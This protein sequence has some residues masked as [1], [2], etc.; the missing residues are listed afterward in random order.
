MGILRFNYRSEVLGRYV[1][2]TV[3]L[4][5]DSYRC[6]PSEKLENRTNRHPVD[7]NKPCYVPGMKFQTVY[8]IHGGGDDDTLTYR[9]SNVEEVAQRNHVMLVTPNIA[10]SFGYDAAYT[11]PYMTFVTEELPTVIQSLF[12]SSTARE[13]NFIMGYAMGGNVALGCAV[14]RPDRYA[15]C[16]D[17]SGG[18][19][20]TMST[21]T[22]M[23]ELD[24]DHFKQFFPL[25]NTTFGSSEEI[26]GSAADLAY[27]VKQHRENGDPEC[28]FLLVCGSREFIR[29][30]VERDAAVMQ[31][32]HMDVTYI[33]AEEYDHDFKLWDRY[34]QLGLDTLLPLKRKA[35][36]PVNAQ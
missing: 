23:E 5:T 14:N 2:I 33:C 19:G 34:M 4:P 26:P 20:M 24:G 6:P 12:P 35:I 21:E 27:Q 15:M 1:D 25:Y 11:I 32:M 17:I 7:P 16:M 29:Q 13:D 22:L 30:R 3:A 18:I 28:R 31:E 8:L 9:Y 10:N 36:Y